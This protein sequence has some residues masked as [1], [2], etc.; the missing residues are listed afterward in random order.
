MFEIG[1]DVEDTFVEISKD[2][3][4]WASVGKVFG[5]TSGTDIDFYGFGTGDQLRFV[6][7]TDDGAEGN[8]TGD[9]VGADIDSLGA[10]SSVSV[11]PAIPEPQTYAL[12]LGGLA[13]V[14]AAARRPYAKRIR[15]AGRAVNP[16]GRARERRRT[17]YQS[18]PASASCAA[19][20]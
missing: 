18:A 7:L 4:A 3:V 8:Q 9:S 15:P 10:I 17:R 5:A 1:P 19:P 16:A 13:L 12:M 11:T 2:G 14:V 20:R 6:R